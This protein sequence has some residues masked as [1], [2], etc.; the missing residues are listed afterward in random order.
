MQEKA[1]L[2]QISVD[3][4]NTESEIF[5]WVRGNLIV[6]LQSTYWS[7]GNSS[8]AEATD[9]VQEFCDQN[10]L[11]GR[12]CQESW[13][14]KFFLDESKGKYELPYVRRTAL[15]KY[16]LLVGGIDITQ[17]RGGQ[18]LCTAPGIIEWTSVLNT[19]HWKSL[20]KDLYSPAPAYKCYQEETKENVEHGIEFDNVF[21]R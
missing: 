3:R 12:P 6:D 16:N 21:P 18:K 14:P 1:G 5:D 19:E 9:G 8:Y 17:N 11:L 2:D 20:T 7:I 10:R 15:R 13:Y 4:I